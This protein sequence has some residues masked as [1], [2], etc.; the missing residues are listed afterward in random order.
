V[1][2]TVEAGSRS[3][4]LSLS[5]AGRAEQVR[6]SQALAAGISVVGEAQG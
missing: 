3:R 1:A 2:L 6:I 4:T 5:V